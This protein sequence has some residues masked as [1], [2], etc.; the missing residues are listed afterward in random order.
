[1]YGCILMT[2]SIWHLGAQ[3][4][5]LEEAERP[6]VFLVERLDRSEFPLDIPCFLKLL[7]MWEISLKQLVS[8]LRCA[9][10]WRHGR[11]SRPFGWHLY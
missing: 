9:L 3:D 10:G 8:T 5:E 4:M 7:S 1:M 2:Y 6:G 11:Y